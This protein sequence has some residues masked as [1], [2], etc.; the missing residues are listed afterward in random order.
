[1]QWWSVK[2]GYLTLAE[3]VEDHIYFALEEL[4][5]QK[6]RYYASKDADANPIKTK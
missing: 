4:Q 3:I 5:V 1:M 2:L 6:S